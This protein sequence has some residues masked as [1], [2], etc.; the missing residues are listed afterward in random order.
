[1]PGTVHGRLT[2]GN[3]LG[4]VAPYSGD[5]NNDGSASLRYRAVGGLWSGWIEMGKGGLHYVELLDLEVGTEY[6]IEVSYADPDSSGQETQ[7]LSLYMGKACIP[8]ALRS[9]AG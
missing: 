2:C 9:Y 1:M 8:I 5:D 4:V 6:E 3:G 7:S